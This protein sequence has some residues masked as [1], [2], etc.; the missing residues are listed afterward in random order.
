MRLKSQRSTICER[1]HVIPRI[2]FSVLDRQKNARSFC[3]EE[4]YE[5]RLGLSDIEEG[6][7]TDGARSDNSNSGL[8]EQKPSLIQESEEE[9]HLSMKQRHVAEKGQDYV[10]RFFDTPFEEVEQE[11]RSRSIYRNFKTWRLVNIMVKTGD[12]LKQGSQRD[13]I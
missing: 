12:N 1:T 2:S 9:P 11:I 8:D 4:N 10:D 3:A 7:Q 5:N 13:A 6:S